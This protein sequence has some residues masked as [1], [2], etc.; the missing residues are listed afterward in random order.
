MKRFAILGNSGSGKSSLAK[1]LA[2]S[3]GLD[4]LD[5]DTVGWEPDRPG[6]PRDAALAAADVAAFCASRTGWVVEGCYG[7]LIGAALAFEPV[8]VF[9][10]PGVERCRANC[11]SRP[12]EPHKYR[13]KEEQDANLAFLLSWV[14]EY[15]TRDGP[16]S[17]RAHRQT[18]AGYAGPKTE[19]R[20]VPYLNPPDAEVAALL[21]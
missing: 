12:W 13:S 18:F 1:W 4:V 20:R 2:A 11:R 8:L 17:L 10:N 16:M 7:D 3:A 21:R 19:L 6:T 5:L 14:A 9:L 15:E